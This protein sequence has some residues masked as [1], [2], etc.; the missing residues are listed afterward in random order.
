MHLQLVG[1]VQKDGEIDVT[2]HVAG[3]HGAKEGIESSTRFRSRCCE[4]DA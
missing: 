3:E 1:L 2:K 4:M